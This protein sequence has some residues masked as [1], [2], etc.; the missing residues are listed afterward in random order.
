MPENFVQLSQKDAEKL[1]LKDG[2]LVDVR[3]RRGAV[4]LVAK[5]GEIDD[6]QIFIPFHFGSIDNKGGA[7]QAGNE[8]TK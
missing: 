5:V 8:L 1:D 2:D 3:S 4:R 7:A 6:G